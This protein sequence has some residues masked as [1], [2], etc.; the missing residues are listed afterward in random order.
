[1]TSQENSLIRIGW[2]EWIGLP[3][4]GIESIKAK[5]DTGARTSS[6]HAFDVE[7]F[8]KNGAD[9]VRFRVH[10]LQKNTEF[11]VSAVAPLIDVR[12]VR[13]SN[14]HVS[15]RPVISTSVQLFDEAWTIQLTLANRDQMGFRMLLGRE[16]LRRRFLVDA[17]TSFRDTSHIP[18]L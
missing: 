18:G 9:F 14:G 1:M 13:S 5:I 7:R 12:L 17:G 3:D 2:R 8:R 15:E 16:A 4:L 6:L 11:A 10:P